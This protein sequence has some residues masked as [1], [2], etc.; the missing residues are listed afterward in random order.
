MLEGL[1]VALLGSQ[2]DFI[3]LDNF[4]ENNGYYSIADAGVLD[5][6]KQDKNVY[7]TSKDDQDNIL[8]TFDL[9]SNNYLD[10]SDNFYLEVTGIELA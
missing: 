6:I 7:Y 2:I 10:N 5:D 8:I 3:S 1:K 9:I 4:M